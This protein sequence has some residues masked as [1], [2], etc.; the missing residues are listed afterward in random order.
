M[1]HDRPRSDS[2][3]GLYA[4]AAAGVSGFRDEIFYRKGYFSLNSPLNGSL[5]VTVSITPPRPAAFARCIS[6]PIRSPSQVGFDVHVLRTVDPNT[7]TRAS[8]VK[9]RVRPMICR[10]KSQTRS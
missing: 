4:D 7:R 3:P 5:F 2:L 6:S 9:F 10:R 8:R 1:E